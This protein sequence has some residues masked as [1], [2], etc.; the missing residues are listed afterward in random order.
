VCLL[1]PAALQRVLGLCLALLDSAG[2]RPDTHQQH[3]VEQFVLL[4][5]AAPRMAA[6]APATLKVR[7]AAVQCLNDRSDNTLCRVVCVLR[8][9]SSGT[10]ELLYPLLLS[11]KPDTLLGC[12]QVRLLQPVVM[13]QQLLPAATQ[14][15]R[16]GRL[17]GT[18]ALHCLANV[19]Q[20][21]TDC[22]QQQQQ[23]RPAVVPPS[24]HLEV[25]ATTEA[26]C[27][28]A[29]QLLSA[30]TR[31]TQGYSSKQQ[32]TSAAA[33]SN[34]SR[35]SQHAKQQRSCSSSSGVAA[36]AASILRDGC[37][38]LGSQQHLLQLMKVL[39]SHSQEGMV[40]WAAYCVH[41]LQDSAKVHAAAAASATGAV[42]DITGADNGSS[43]AAAGNGQV[44][45]AVL[46][47]VA[48]APGILPG[49]WRW[50]ALAVGLPL[51]AP[52]QASRG[53]DIA[54]V[55]GGPD[56]LPKPV[57]VVMGLFCRWAGA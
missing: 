11:S 18:A 21:L 1:L 41:L 43:K 36:E 2:S 46:N 24:Q 42:A 32:H 47:V 33:S 52:L 39:T 34:A 14:L 25:G 10:G 56:G 54:A 8:L 29:L 53:L 17:S 3:F 15:A 31:L 28:A 5:A 7:L 48:F 4:L 57:A 55:A 23:Q 44:A 38:M 19:A 16:S 12:A 6:A 27:R 40:L 35:G 51:E 49:V 45:T 20:L 26:Y 22:S 37:W 50:L 13:Q 30:G 9:L